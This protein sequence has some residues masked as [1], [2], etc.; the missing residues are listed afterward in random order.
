M[1]VTNDPQETISKQL[2]FEAGPELRRQM[3]ADV[4]QAHDQATGTGSSGRTAA[5]WKKVGV[6]AA[7]AITILVI[8]ILLIQGSPERTHDVIQANGAESQLDM[9]TEISLE[10]AF[11]RGGVEAIHDQYKSALEMSGPQVSAPSVD[12]LLAD[13]GINGK[14]PGGMDIW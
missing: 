1:N 7:A 3:L 2:R 12:Q 4:L 10:R 11:R 13:L 6:A 5:L 9:L 8:G 14:H